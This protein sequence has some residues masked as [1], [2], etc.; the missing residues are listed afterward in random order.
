MFN[1]LKGCWTAQLQLYC[2]WCLVCPPWSHSCHRTEPSPRNW[3]LFGV[4]CNTGIVIQEQNSA[5]QSDRPLEK[6]GRSKW[7]SVRQMTVPVMSENEK[8]SNETVAE[9]K[10]VRAE[11]ANEERKVTEE[12]KNE[13]EEEK[14]SPVHKVRF[15][16]SSFWMCVSQ[17][18][19]V[20]R[21]RQIA[22]GSFLWSASALAAFEYL[23]FVGWI[24][25]NCFRKFMQCKI[26]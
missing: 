6:R 18:R 17:K 24:F 20:H 3:D 7:E 26:L 19:R 13:D 1:F 9:V 4:I 15:H 5:S 12:E 10:E 25:V 14:L 11:V 16:G 2:D 22:N 8:P 23:A 21:K